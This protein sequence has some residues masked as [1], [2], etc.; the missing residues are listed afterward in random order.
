MRP[1]CPDR[2]PDAPM[3]SDD[4]LRAIQSR[5]ARIAVGA[6]T[7]RGRGHTG[8]VRE[9]RQHF[10]KMD[11]RVF[12]VAPSRFRAVLDRETLRL[13]SALPKA[14]RRWGIAR[15]LLNIFLRDCFYTGQLS[16]AYRL[17]TL[18]TEFEIPL[19]SITAKALKQTMGRGALPQWPGVKHLTPELSE[20]FQTAALEEAERRGI[21]RVHLDAVWWSLDRDEE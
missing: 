1:P 5:A 16:E 3:P 6:S 2:H 7:V 21:A 9:A 19:D 4:L 8:T 18:E 15:K 17:A 14:A 11:L 13:Q 20:V 10:S 12:G